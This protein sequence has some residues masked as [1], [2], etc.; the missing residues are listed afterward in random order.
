M[1]KLTEF[2]ESFNRKERFFLVGEVLG[3]PGFDLAPDFRDRLGSAFGLTVPSDS[4]VAMD[5]H[6]D[7]IHTSLYLAQHGGN[8]VSVHDNEEPV[9]HGN[10]EDVDLLVAFEDSPVTHLL[11]IEAKA[12]TSWSNN[13]M[14]SKAARLK[15]IFGEDGKRYPNVIPYFGLMS[16]HPHNKLDVKT[17]P[18]W[19]V[20]GGAV[21]PLELKLPRWRRRVGRTDASGK[22]FRV[23]MSKQNQ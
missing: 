3:N 9:V 10:Q 5:Y 8:D 20:P 18:G 21:V 7:W 12:Y 6:L 23:W 2:L 11:L 19:M 16:R 22:F 17:W 15:Q 1:P 14:C 13:Q 4:F